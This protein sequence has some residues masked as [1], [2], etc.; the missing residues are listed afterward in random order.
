L[1]DDLVVGGRFLS[2]SV[3][4]LELN[5]WQVADPLAERNGTRAASA[6]R[7]RLTVVRGG[8]TQVSTRLPVYAYCT[9][10]FVDRDG[11]S[12]NQRALQALNVP[13]AHRVADYHEEPDLQ[14]S[15]RSALYH[16]DRVIGFYVDNC[17]LFEKMD[18]PAGTFRGNTHESRIHLELD[19][20]L[21]AVRRTYDFTANLL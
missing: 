17:A 5:R 11:S 13:S 1:I 3:L 12:L 2:V 4:L 18:H 6:G 19:A 10:T 7:P 8:V 15:L 9:V 20:L 14:Y 21:A 16:L